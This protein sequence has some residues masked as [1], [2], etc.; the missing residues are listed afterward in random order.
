M[1]KANRV[2][3]QLTQIVMRDVPELR[4]SWNSA[5]IQC[6]QERERDRKKG[7]EIKRERGRQAEVER[8]LFKHEL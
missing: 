7:R 6:R 4:M 3:R 8:T 1:S 5:P 2:A